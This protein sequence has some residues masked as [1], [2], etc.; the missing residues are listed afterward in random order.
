ML[1]AQMG[2][3]AHN[4]GQGF[5]KNCE[6][7]FYLLTEKC[8]KLCVKKNIKNCIKVM[9]YFQRTAELSVLLGSRGTFSPS[10]V[11]FCP[12]VGDSGF[13]HC[14]PT[15]LTIIN[16][17]HSL[18]RGEQ[19]AYYMLASKL[20]K[21]NT[22]YWRKAVLQTMFDISISFSLGFQGGWW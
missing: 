19:A 6:V 17:Y 3:P 13:G 11:L 14:Q 2:I 20:S 9:L 22:I 15:E 7:A 18:V 1:L 16:R 10:A 4:L 12:L 5:L 21:L 8:P